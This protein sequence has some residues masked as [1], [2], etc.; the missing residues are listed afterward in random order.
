METTRFGNTGL[1][2]SR[3]CLGC[4][5]YGS[6]KWREWILEEEASRPFLREAFEKGVNFFDTADVYSQGASEEIVGRA[7]KEL[8]QRREFV[9]ATK[10]HGQMGKSLNGGGL[11][12][13]HILEA[14]DQSL[15]RLQTDYVDLYQIHRLDGQTPMEETLEALNDVVRAGKALYVGASSMFAWQFAKMDGLAAAKGQAQ[16]V[17]MQNYYNLVY[18]EEEREMMPYCANEGIAVIPWSPMARGFLAGAGLGPNASTVRGRT[19][20]YSGALG[21]GSEQDE[22]IRLRVVETARD[23]GTK[24]AIVALAWVLS[25]PYVTAPIV[26]ASKPGHIDDAIAALSLKLDAATI[27]RLEEPYRPKGV[28]G[29]E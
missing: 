17:S 25:K 12:R 8:G 11:S 7:M 18:R 14:I 5:T 27:A 20:P 15:K 2:V 1:K 21:L 10:V 24:P 23:L 16:F 3:L 26:G 28:V 6:R 29:H 22:A 19:D 4:M 9:L 13:K